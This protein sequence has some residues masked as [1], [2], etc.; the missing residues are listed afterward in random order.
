MLGL[1]IAFFLAACYQA[2]RAEYYKRRA[3]DPWATAWKDFQKRQKLPRRH[4][5]F[6]DQDAR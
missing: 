4:P 6:F 2:G 3:V 1:T 5:S